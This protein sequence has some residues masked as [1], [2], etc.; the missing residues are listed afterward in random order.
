VKLVMARINTEPGLE[1]SSGISVRWSIMSKFDE[2]CAAYAALK[3]DWTAYQER[4]VR[5]YHKLVSG[6]MQYSGIPNNKLEIVPVNEEP[7]AG[8]SYGIPGEMHFDKESR[9]WHLAFVLT[10]HIAPNVIYP[11]Q[12]IRMIICLMEK[13]GKVYVKYDPEGDIKEIDLKDEKQC[14]EFYDFIVNRVKKYFTY[15]M[16]EYLEGSTSERTIG[17]TPPSPGD[18]PLITD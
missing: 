17:F 18:V 5:H 16:D 2:M 12:R 15:K 3:T 14:E 7:R 10:L 13:A 9:F 4:C 8:A 11:Q 1:T 6:F